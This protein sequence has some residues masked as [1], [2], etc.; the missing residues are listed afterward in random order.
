MY[1]IYS[2]GD[3]Q[4]LARVFDGVSMLTGSG[5]LVGASAIACLIGVIF[6]CFQS[7]INTQGIKIQNVLVCFVIYLVCFAV[8]TQVN[9]VSSR[10]D[11]DFAQRDNVPLGIAMIG[12]TISTITHEL[13]KKME[14]AMDPILTDSRVINASNGGGYANSL[15]LLN[16]VTRPQTG[17]VIDVV[18]DISPNF[19]YN[20]TNYCAECTVIKY[21]LGGKNYSKDFSLLVTSDA[22][23]AF[24]F[25]SNI[26][27]T[28]LIDPA[29]GEADDYSCAAGGEKIVSW[30]NDAVKNMD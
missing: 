28:S 29:T 13:T 11:S 6:L 12:S 10:D 7:V 8:P 2:I 16:H 21:L 22:M 4:F 26:Y 14:L 3:V 20:L 9:I 17:Y 30:W 15:Y 18:E 23:D 24:K 27:Y 25:N 5:S 1:T 19:K